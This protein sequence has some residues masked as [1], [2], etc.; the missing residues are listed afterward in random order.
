MIRVLIFFVVLAAL[1]YGGMLVVQNPGHV[2]LTWHDQV[3]NAPAALLIAAVALAAIIVWSVLRFVLGLPSFVGFMARQ[4]KRD[5]GYAALSR[6]LVALGSGDV[7][8]AGKASSQASRHLKNDP[9]ALMLRAQAAHQAGDG[10]D[11]QAA[12]EELAQREDTRILGLR[13]L[14]AEAARRGDDEAARHFAAAAHRSAPLPWS[15]E[16][17]LAHRAS[18][19]EW[20]KALMTVETS[21]A[22]KLIDKQTG[23]R[24]RAVLETAIAAEKETMS[25][26]VALQMARSAMKRAPD[27]VP[28]VVIAARLL[29]RRGDIRKATKMIERAW[30]R[31]QHPDI[32]RAYLDV[33]PGD[34]TTDRLSRAKTLMGIASFDPVSRLTVARAALAGKDFTTARNAMAPLVGEGTRPTVRMCMLMAEIEDAE[35]G[36]LGQWREWL[37]RASHAALDSA[38]VSD[39]IVYDHWAP[40]SPTTG[41]LDT[42][43][44]QVPAERLGPAMDA[45]PPRRR[46]ELP[47]MDVP[48][49]TPVDT[50]MLGA[51]IAAEPEVLASGASAVGD[52]HAHVDTPVVVES[53]PLPDHHQA[54]ITSR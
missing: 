3:V 15:A 33:R 20:E 21:L 6:G 9:L 48:T 31:C 41:K 10:A 4:R 7:R 47:A 36:D 30:P 13:G 46:E 39:G 14:H 1:A 23:E 45:L 54:A 52:D 27:L 8:G 26:D 40:T 29:T 53:E 38:W 16:A 49:L 51:P 22:A 2:T 43:H 50:A 42:F 25:P 19:G 28:P 18:E 12:Y 24:Q 17:V 37:A 11:A 44:W 35:H 32:A 34:S 5:K